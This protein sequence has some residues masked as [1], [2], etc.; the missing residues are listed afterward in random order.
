[1]KRWFL[2]KQFY[3][4]NASGVALVAYF[5]CLLRESGQEENLQGRKPRKGENGVIGILIKMCG[6][7]YLGVEGALKPTTP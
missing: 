2:R 3:R 6:N 4:S 1:M 7:V 5:W